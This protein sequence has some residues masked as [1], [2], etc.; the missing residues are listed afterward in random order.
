MRFLL[1]KNQLGM[2]GGAPQT[3]APTLHA[4]IAQRGG[5]S[6]VRSRNNPGVRRWMHIDSQGQIIHRNEA[7][8]T[9]REVHRAGGKLPMSQARAEQEHVWHLHRQG[10]IDLKSNPIHHTHPFTA[11]LTPHGRRQVAQ[12]HAADAAGHAARQSGLFKARFLFFVMHLAQQLGLFN[13][14]PPPAPPGPLR[15]EEVKAHQAANPS[16]TG[17]HTVAAHTR[18]V[19]AGQTVAV[20]KVKVTGRKADGPEG[21]YSVKQ[22]RGLAYAEHGT[23]ANEWRVPE[24]KEA[25]VVAGPKGEDR[26]VLDYDVPSHYKLAETQWSKGAQGGVCHLCGTAIQNVAH[27][28]NDKRELYMP[29]GTTCVTKHTAAMDP[30]HADVSV[31]RANMKIK[32]HEVEAVNHLLRAG[33]GTENAVGIAR[34]VRAAMNRWEKKW[35]RPSAEVAQWWD[36]RRAQVQWAAEKKRLAG[37][38]E[39]PLSSAD[40]EAMRLPRYDRLHRT[41]DPIE[42][43]GHL[44]EL[45]Q[46]LAPGRYEV[47]GHQ[48][49]V[50]LAMA[51]RMAKPWRT[52]HLEWSTSWKD[53]PE[54]HA[55]TVEAFGGA[56][57][58]T[59]LHGDILPPN[60]RLNQTAEEAWNEGHGKARAEALAEALAEH[61]PTLQHGASIAAKSKLRAGDVEWVRS[62]YE[63]LPAATRAPYGGIWPVN[64]SETSVRRHL[65]AVMLYH[66]SHPTAY[67]REQ[68]VTDRAA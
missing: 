25:S 61:H 43:Y 50:S 52:N 16:G 11:V 58:R 22:A 1:R 39:R 67:R 41:A 54:L 34:T 51:E 5:L 33:H 56:L 38:Y 31:K 62:Q 63:A 46:P 44:R 45:G 49:R 6:L 15:V 14:P 13:R 32:P 29:V 8:A 27:I 23:T 66:Q 30:L 48:I 57:P 64:P 37:P 28:V 9:M 7:A 60:A 4:P 35:P 19:H 3:R 26:V 2:F 59:M 68:A 40:H 12:M 17:T 20:D 21:T 47:M 42:V 65:S 55:L 24:V 53:A 18:M 36:R 10:V